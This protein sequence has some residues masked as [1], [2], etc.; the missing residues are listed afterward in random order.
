MGLT[1]SLILIAL[2]LMARWLKD[3]RRSLAVSQIG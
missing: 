1:V 3:S 2:V